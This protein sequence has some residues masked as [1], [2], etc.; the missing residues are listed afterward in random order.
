MERDRVGA[1]IFHVFFSHW[2][3]AVVRERFDEALAAFVTGAA[4]GLSTALLAEDPFSWFTTGKREQAILGAMDSALEWL[5]ERLGLEMRQWT[6]SKLH[7]LSLRHILSG[8]G[9]LDQ[10]LDHGGLPVPG[11]MHTVCNTGLGPGFE[12]RSGAGYRLIADL[13]T[14]PPNLCAVDAQSQSGHPGSPHYS[15]QFQSWIKGEYH[16][17]FLDRAK[18]SRFTATRLVLEPLASRDCC[19]RR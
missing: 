10:L 4:G 11:D 6:W 1:T 2:A 5:T 7:T 8:R 16:P 19:S 9:D 13:S 12:A 15:D 14:S 17:L 3:R 18:G